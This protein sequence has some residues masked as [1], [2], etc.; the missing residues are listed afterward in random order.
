MGTK[1]KFSVFRF[2]IIPIEKQLSLLYDINEYIEKKNS[3]FAGYLEKLH[4]KTPHAKKP[5]YTYRVTKQYVDKYLLISSAQRNVHYYNEQHEKDSIQSYPPAHILIDNDPISQLI[6][7]ESS[8]DYAS[9]LTLIRHFKKIISKLLEDDHLC[10]KIVP[11]YKERSFWEF[12][13]QHH[14]SINLLRFTL[15]TPNMSNISGGLSEDLKCIAKGSKAASSEITLRPEPNAVL[16]IKHDNQGISNLANY[17]S[18]GGGTVQ[19]RLKNSKLRYNSSDHQ[20]AIEIG[21]A[22]IDGDLRAMFDFISRFV[23]EN[24]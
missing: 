6:L 13:K 4:L 19:A 9:P 5:K 20:M 8:K 14:N 3:L 7:V 1:R 15:I 2:Q 21:E 11:I 18:Q 10:M 22:E 12:V 24:D 16:D 17:T 23:R